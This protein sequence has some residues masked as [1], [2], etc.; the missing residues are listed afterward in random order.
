[1][2]ESIVSRLDGNESWRQR[3]AQG[4]LH[5]VHMLVANAP[6]HR[7]HRS[8]LQLRE[9]EIEQGRFYMKLNSKGPIAQQEIEGHLVE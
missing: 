2:L 5:L 1:M 3:S 4:R 9:V 7:F 8:S 6:S